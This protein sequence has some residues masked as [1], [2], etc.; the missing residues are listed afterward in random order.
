M[1]V[2]AKE[3]QCIVLDLLFHYHH[4]GDDTLF[5][6]CETYILFLKKHYSHICAPNH[7]YLGMCVCAHACTP[8]IYVCIRMSTV[9]DM[10]FS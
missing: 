4:G 1:L 7:M 9:V 10:C 2:N 8:C 6:I 3:S 5:C